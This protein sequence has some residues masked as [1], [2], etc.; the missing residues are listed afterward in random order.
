ME[1]QTLVSGYRLDTGAAGQRAN[2]FL[3]KKNEFRFVFIGDGT[4]ATLFLTDNPKKCVRVCVYT[5][6]E[7]QHFSSIQKKEL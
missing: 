5:E 6:S 2:M 4:S 3:T 1:Y 7:I